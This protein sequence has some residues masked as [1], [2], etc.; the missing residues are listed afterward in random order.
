MHIELDRTFR[1]L[2]LKEQM[3]DTEQLQPG[4]ATFTLPAL[5]DELRV[6]VLSE[7]GSGKTQEIREAARRLRRDGKEA[8]FLR[9]EHVGQDFDSAFEVGS[10]EQFQAWL[11]SPNPGWVLLD[12]IDESRLRSPLDFAAAMRVVGKRLSTAKPRTHLLLTGRAAAWRP[13]TDLELCDSLFHIEAG[14]AAGTEGDIGTQDT[15]IVDSAGSQFK[16]VTLQELSRDQIKTFASAKGIADTER[17]LDDIERADA[18]SFTARPQD[19]L[20]L[21]EYWLDKKCIGSRLELMKNSVKRRLK[22]PSQSRAEAQPLPDDKALE[23][24]QL[25]AAALML[26][27]IQNIRVPDGINGARGLDAGDLLNDWPAPLLG[28]LLQRPLFDQD[29]YGTVR[30]HHRSVKEYLAAQWFLKLLGHETSRRRVEELFVR[31]QYGLEVVVPSLR[32]LLPWL[33]VEDS[34]ILARVR[35]IAPEILFE[36]GDPVRL[37]VDVRSDT[38]EQVCAQMANGASSMSMADFSAIQRFAAHDLTDALRRLVRSHE[39]NEEIVYFL[40]RMVWQGRLGG[41]LAE[42]LHVAKSP[43]TQDGARVAAFR[44]VAEVGDAADMASIRDSFLREPGELSRRC[45]A[46]LV[47]HIERPDQETLQWLLGC[48]P[49]LALR[50][51]FS[52]TGLSEQ[53]ASFFDRTEVALV[54]GAIDRLHAMLV[55]PPVFERRHF[56]VSLRYR[57]LCRPVGAAVRRLAALRDP[58]ALRPSAL[59]VLYLLPLDAQYNDHAFDLEKLGL[60]KLV[61]QWPALHWA[62]FWHVVEQERANKAETDGR[63]TEAWMALSVARYVSFE[64]PDFDAAVDAIDSRTLPEDRMMALTLGFRLYA[65]AGHKPEH[66]S[67]LR[68]AA[69]ADTHLAARVELLLNPPEKDAAAMRI[70]KE[71]ARWSRQAKART[72]RIEKARRDAPARLDALVDHLRDPGFDDPIAVSQAQGYMLDRMRELDENKGS[73]WSNGHWRGLERE[74]GIKS[75]RAFRDGIVRFWRR[76]VPK[77]VSE[78]AEI[79][80][81]S[82]ADLFGLTGLTIEA[83]E[84]PRLCVSLSADEAA[85]AFRYAVR[86]LNGFPQWFPALFN[87]HPAIVKSMTLAE[88]GHELQMDQADTASQYFI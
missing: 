86:E 44:A 24:V 45:M 79:G 69:A 65:L 31:E 68:T 35:Q 13:Q 10:L 56:E 77:L 62:L 78:G 51:E 27:G 54:A 20:E 84:D 75:P 88:V 74:F 30:F 40:M 60:A 64:A 55:E 63:V 59:A 81:M 87:A 71:N 23:G 17:F 26:T 29:I 12:S 9:L 18:W 42:A 19:L 72:A 80:K 1:E 21:T 48:I 66:A 73:R 58:A 11:V 15:V 33:A 28:T 49:R 39:A 7:G 50:K 47:S 38:L 36:G 67:R 2:L 3:A 22:E 76:H 14:R 4:P 25:I 83:T 61:Q 85:V 46:D 16:I 53:I 34:R 8:F 5:L 52:P 82:L 32:P 57:W 37:P 41:A 43:H 6:V 70:E